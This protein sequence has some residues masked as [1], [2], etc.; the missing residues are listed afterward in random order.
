MTRAADA[1]SALDALRRVVRY[2]R[3]AD[4]EVE[5]AC[6]LSVAQLFVLQTLS[7][8][9]AMSLAEVAQRT[10]TDQSSVSTV[11]ARLVERKLIDR[12]PSPVDRRRAELWLTPAGRRVVLTAPRAPQARMISTID[13]MTAE[14]RTE[15]VRGLEGLAA[16]IG[17]N[18]VS[19]AM[20]FE[21]EPATRNGRHR[22]GTRGRA[23]AASG[24]SPRA[25]GRSRA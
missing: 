21:D 3:L 23:R 11:V 24:T 20:L 17:A 15:L 25:R 4:R 22:R 13:E 5:Q 8:T 16:A 9:P 19:P 7:D 18:A 6:G 12:K 2:L 14:R 1:A 10:L